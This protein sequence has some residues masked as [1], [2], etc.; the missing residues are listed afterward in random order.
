MRVF[1][2]TTYEVTDTDVL[3]LGT[4]GLWDITSNEEAVRLISTSLQQFPSDD[5][6]RYKYR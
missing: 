3:I 2:L 5:L 1:D 4:D 6:N